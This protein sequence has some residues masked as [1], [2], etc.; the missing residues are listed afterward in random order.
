MLIKELEQ[1]L[2]IQELEDEDGDEDGIDDSIHSMIWEAYV[3][4]Q[5]HRYLETRGHIS[6]APN[7]L[8]W[9]LATFSDFTISVTP[10]YTKIV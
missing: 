6:R 9:L 3:Q 5:S 4:T 10:D 1:M 2:V 8:D 7:R